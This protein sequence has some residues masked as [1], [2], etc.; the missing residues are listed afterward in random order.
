MTN[1]R[2]QPEEIIT[3]LRQVEVSLG[4]GTSRLD[5]SR[6]MQISSLKKVAKLQKIIERLSGG[7]IVQNRQLKTVLGTEEYARYLSDCEYQRY[8]RAMLKDKP[9]EIVEYERRLKVATFAYS[10]ADYKSQKG[11]RSAKKMFGASDTQF[12]RLSEYL[13]E[14]II[15]HPELE[16]WF[17]RP[18]AKCLGD[19]FGVSPDG[20]PQVV[21]SKSLKNIGGG[22]VDQLRSIRE[23]KIDA[24]KE[25]IQELTSPAPDV[26]QKAIKARFD[27]L[28][29]LSAD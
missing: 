9:Y 7:E 27:R 29:K 22:Y 12:E 28:R 14:N 1:K 13:S 23:V 19:S 24:V 20:F 15:G 11:H 18:L 26:D 16:A 5:A 10:K 25:A 4:Q 21:T 3:K 8:L 6:L 17:D 2:P